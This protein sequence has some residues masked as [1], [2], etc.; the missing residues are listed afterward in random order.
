MKNFISKTNKYLIQKHPIIWNTKLVWMLSIAYIL[1][2]IFFMLGFVALA[3][4]EVLH[5]YRAKSIFFDNSTVFINVILSILLLVLWLIYLFKNNAFKSFY[6]T[7]NLKIFK[8]F[9]CYLVIVF[10]SISFF[11]SHNLGLKSY[12]NSTYNNDRIKK[13]IQISNDAALFFSQNLN[14]YTLNQRRYPEPLNTLYCETYQGTKLASDSVTPHLS[15][16]DYNYR[17]YTL[18]TKKGLGR[19]IYNDSTYKNFIYYKI[20][21]TVHTYFYKD[22]VYDV[23]NIIKSATPSYYNY[24]KTFY[25]AEDENLHE[26]D[27]T[28]NSNDNYYNDYDNSY[29]NKEFSIRNEIRNKKNHELLTRNNT[30]EIK[31][32]LANFLA[33]VNQYRVAHNLTTN[34]WFDLIYNPND[35]ELKSLIRSEPKRQYEYGFDEA[36]NAPEVFYKNHVTDFYL[37]DNAL[38][39][40]FENIEY[41]KS[42]NL[43]IESIHFFMWASFLLSAIIFMF[44]ITGLKALLFSIITIGLLSVLVGLLTVLCEYLTNFHGNSISY[45]ALYLIFVL[46]TIILSIP[47]CCAKRI[48]KSIVAICLNISIGGLPLYIFLIISIIS[49]HQSDACG[50]YSFNTNSEVCFNLLGSIGTLW[51][52]ILFIIG[53]VFIYFYSKVIKKWKALPEG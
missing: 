2:V 41:I 9:A 46:G 37:D 38:H 31:Q 51:S 26:L 44:R 22:A 21:D 3:N 30:Q 6:P 36:K 52:Y 4:P 7:S 13:E 11:L 12:I 25:V 28:Y 14:D 34:E 39:Q 27:I 5:N 23:S 40:S 43:F 19:N 47:I 49:M 1:H 50:Y 18:K 33:V 35:F 32:L 29:Y 24:S 8:Q 53:L 17:F 48:K 10:S 20:K 16:L 45:F 42:S 15:F